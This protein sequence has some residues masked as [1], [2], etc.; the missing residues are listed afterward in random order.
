[1]WELI[2]EYFGKEVTVQKILE[3]FYYLEGEE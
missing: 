2:L 1:M 3:V